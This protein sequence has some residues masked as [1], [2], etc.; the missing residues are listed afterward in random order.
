MNTQ[1]PLITVEAM[2]RKKPKKRSR[3]RL[4]ATEEECNVLKL[5][6]EKLVR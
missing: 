3:S 5:K 2:Y 1:A 4:A 6:I